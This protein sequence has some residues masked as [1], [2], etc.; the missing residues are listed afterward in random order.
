M[1]R[2][3]IFCILVVIAIT[4]LLVMKITSPGV[5]FKKNIIDPIPKSIANLKVK[6]DMGAMHG[7][8]AFS[9]T[10]S[11][12]DINAIIKH[13]GLKEHKE[14]PD[15]ISQIIGRFAKIEWWE[16]LNNFKQMKI[17]G[18]ADESGSDYHALFLFIDGNKVYCIEV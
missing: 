15:I 10:A 7:A 8:L 5:L 3:V 9:F 11:Q 12:D 1:K 18:K 4:V 6:K 13:T 14:I 16:P 17:F 2:I